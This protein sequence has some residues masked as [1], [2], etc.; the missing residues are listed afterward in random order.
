MHPCEVMKETQAHFNDRRI[1]IH[2]YAVASFTVVPGH[3]GGT[4]FSE[5]SAFDRYKVRG[6]FSELLTLTRFARILRSVL[7][8]PSVLEACMIELRSSFRSRLTVIKK[9]REMAPLYIHMPNI[10]CCL[11]WLCLAELVINAYANA[12]RCSR[13]S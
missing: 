13:L 6:N 10:K 5:Y 2:P 11:R 12:A 9:I 7:L 4:K 1:R 8:R 3:F